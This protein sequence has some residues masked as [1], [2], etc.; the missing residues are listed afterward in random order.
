MTGEAEDL[1]RDDDGVLDEVKWINVD[2]VSVIGAGPGDCVYGDV[3][4]GPDGASVPAHLYRCTPDGT[5]QFGPFMIIGGL[6]TPGAVNA[7]CLRPV[8]KGGS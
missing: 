4:V 8:Q 7:A 3:I 1:D 2:S 5:W 6:D